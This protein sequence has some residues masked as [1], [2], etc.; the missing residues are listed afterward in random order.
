VLVFGTT[1]N[2]LGVWQMSIGQGEFLPDRDP[3]RGGSEAVLGAKLARELFGDE[4]ALGKFVRIGPERLRV[5]GVV[6]PK[7]NILGF[8]MDDIAF[9]PVATSMGMFNT[10]ELFEIDLV[11]AHTDMTQEVVDGATRLLSQR[12]GGKQDFT[13]I[14]QAA[15]LDV[16]DRVMRVVTTAVGAIA[17]ISLLVGAIGI[18]TIMWIAVGERV[19]EIGLLRALGATSRQIQRQ[20]L[21]EAVAL[22]ACGGVAGL[23]VGGAILA[24]LQLFVPGMPVHTPPE[25]VLAALVVSALTGLAS[26][27]APARRAAA[28]DP[29]EA[30]RAE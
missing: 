16:F 11:F 30:L 9:V 25:Y 20:F 21:F 17:G 23:L 4:N 10:D 14:T 5:I 22:A 12:H 24:L 29:I 2:A 7:G 13:V 8:D 6:A 28:L 18:L 3:R 27:V 15:M 1:S 19:P 26:G